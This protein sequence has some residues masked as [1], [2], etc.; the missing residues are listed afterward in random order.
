[1]IF[2]VDPVAVDTYFAILFVIKQIK[3]GYLAATVSFAGTIYLRKLTV[4]K[5]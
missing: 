4:E 2:G 5:V 1:V 3:I